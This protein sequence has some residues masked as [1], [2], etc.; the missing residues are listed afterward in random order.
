V[1]NCGAGRGK[2]HPQNPNSQG[3][4]TCGATGII[5][6]ATGRGSKNGSQ[7]RH[8]SCGAHKTTLHQEQPEKSIP[9]GVTA[10][11]V[12]ALNG[13]PLASRLI[14]TDEGVQF[15]VPPLMGTNASARIE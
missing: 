14:E 15:D 3:L 4:P 8:I 9:S 12:T 13:F 2:P 10:G 7:G 11:P 5:Q 1:Q 6:T